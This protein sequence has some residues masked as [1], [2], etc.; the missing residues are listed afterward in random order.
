MNRE[1]ELPAFA[2]IASVRLGVGKVEE[3]DQEVVRLEEVWRDGPPKILVEFG[4]YVVTRWPLLSR[5]S[6]P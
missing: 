1:T 5:I 3:V 2:L 4:R 6:I